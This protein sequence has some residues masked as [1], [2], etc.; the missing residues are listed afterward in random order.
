MSV[1]RIGITFLHAVQEDAALLELYFSVPPRRRQEWVRRNLIMPGA[2]NS[3]VSM[4]PS[5]FDA[6]EDD[7]IQVDDVS[8]RL[9]VRMYTNMPGEREFLAEYEA[10]P[11]RRRSEWI[12]ARLVHAV[13]GQ[14][15]GSSQPGQPVESAGVG[16]SA[17][18]RSGGARSA[19]SARTPGVAEDQKVSPRAFRGLMEGD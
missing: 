9:E 12:R 4:P 10:V 19:A 15:W 13:L 2:A 17:G 6:S 18:A 7:A 3:I 5:L 11:T 16:A 8:I 1:R 14:G